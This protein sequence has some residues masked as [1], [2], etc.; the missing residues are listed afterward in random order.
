MS[1]FCGIRLQNDLLRNNS[2]PFYT[3]YALFENDISKYCVSLQHLEGP[4]TRK[5]HDY[6]P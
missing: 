4:D 2:N 6:L 5:K 3:K 1:C